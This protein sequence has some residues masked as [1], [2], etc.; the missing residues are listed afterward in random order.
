MLFR[1]GIKLKSGDELA[2]MVVIEKGEKLLVVTEKGYGKRV[3]YKLFSA[4]SRGTGGQIYIKVVE[5]TGEVASVR[6]VA[7]DDEF[8]AITSMGM[9]IR[10]MVK[11]VSIQG[12]T[13]KGVRLIS[14]KDPDMVVDIGRVEADEEA[15]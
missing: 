6:G 5:S 15:E 4:H 1:S 3:E 13:A 11:E 12:R 2:G 7:D 10:S 9:I 14:V 8:F